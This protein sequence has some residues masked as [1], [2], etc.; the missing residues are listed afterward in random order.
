M[1]ATLSQ[2]IDL[3]IQISILLIIIIGILFFRIKKYN[4]H[5]QLMAIS[6][7]MILVS[8]LLIM[9]PALLMTYMTFLEP[10][11]VVF[12]TASI[13]HIPLGIA[14]LALGGFLV[15]RWARNEFRLNN[16][17]ASWLMRS[18]AVL[19]VANVILGA[20]VYFTMSS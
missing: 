2:T 3:I 19:W 9:L 14:G 15:I 6:F 16:M 11:T 7:F 12:D 17:K 13:V 10:S 8:F 1:A 4:W 5:A 20:T 18:T